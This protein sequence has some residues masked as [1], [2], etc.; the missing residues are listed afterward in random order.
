MG[1]VATHE[2][3]VPAP[4]ANG[5]SDEN[6]AEQSNESSRTHTS[7][8]EGETTTT[9]RNTK[10]KSPKCEHAP[11]RHWCLTPAD[12]LTAACCGIPRP[13]D[14][15]GAVLNACLTPEA[16]TAALLL[17]RRVHQ[18]R[19]PDEETERGAEGMAA[20][21]GRLPGPLGDPGKQAHCS[22]FG[23]GRCQAG[24]V[25]QQTCGRLPAC[26]QCPLQGQALSY[27][28]IL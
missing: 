26:L 20:L 13:Y 6:S 25:S 8:N 28:L 18:L 9:P 22:V 4:G 24:R 5:L 19:M 2:E 12:L 16:M 14:M 1:V 11:P 10:F 17:A 3:P 7:V 21:H 23:G 15:P 27:T